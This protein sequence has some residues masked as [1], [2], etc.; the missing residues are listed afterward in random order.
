MNDKAIVS[1]DD[2]LV[3]TEEASHPV[4]SEGGM[5]EVGKKYDSE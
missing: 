1:V 2:G 4:Q 5:K 3:K